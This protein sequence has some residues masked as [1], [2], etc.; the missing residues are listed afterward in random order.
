MKVFIIPKIYSSSYHFSCNSGSNSLYILESV[1][2]PL[3]LYN[4]KV[5]PTLQFKNLPAWLQYS[6]RTISGCYA[7]LSSLLFIWKDN[8]GSQP[9]I[10]WIVLAI[11]L[12]FQWKYYRHFTGCQ[13]LLTGKTYCLIQWQHSCVYHII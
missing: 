13:G 8:D 2:L 11:T 4:E 3:I 6:L 7:L 12:S 9:A 5:F 1:F 10:I